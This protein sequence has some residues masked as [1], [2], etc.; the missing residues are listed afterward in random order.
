MLTKIISI[1]GPMEIN[2]YFIECKIDNKVEKIND[3]NQLT[4]YKLKN[5]TFSIIKEK[6]IDK[7]YILQLLNISYNNTESLENAIRSSILNQ[8][9]SEII[10]ESKDINKGEYKV[11]PMNEEYFCLDNY[12]YEEMV[13][14]FKLLEEI[15]MIQRNIDSMEVREK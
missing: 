13:Q 6:E 3:V 5:G 8:Y 10:F 2:E 7:E 11:R 12:E 4:Y 14:K 15:K 1:C 9:G